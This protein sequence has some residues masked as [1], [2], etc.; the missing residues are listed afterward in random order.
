[1]KVVNYFCQAWSQIIKLRVPW[2]FFSGCGAV[3]DVRHGCEGAWYGVVNDWCDFQRRLYNLL[4]PIMQRHLCLD[5]SEDCATVGSPSAL[6]TVWGLNNK[7]FL[8]LKFNSVSWGDSVY[9]R[10]SNVNI[11][12]QS[13]PLF[14]LWIWRF[15]KP[16]PEDVAEGLHEVP[17]VSIFVGEGRCGRTRLWWGGSFFPGSLSIRIN[18]IKRTSS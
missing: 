7:H 13:S 3:V 8:N 2:Q 5:P 16:R 17:Y 4:K 9:P 18:C 11:L 10:L 1:M 14:L 15:K 12:L 6:A